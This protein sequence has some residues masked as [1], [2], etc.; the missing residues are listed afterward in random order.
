MGRITEKIKVYN[1]VDLINAETGLIKK[2]LIRSVEINALLDTG[3][4]FVCLPRTEI[5]KLGLRYHK[6]TKIR[7]ANGEA[8]RRI[9]EGAKVELKDR[10][11]EMPIMENDDATP[12]LI[13]YLLLEALDYVIDPQIQRVIPNPAHD[14]K[15]TADL[16]LDITE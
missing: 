12:S 5:E 1:L 16:Y 13:G 4:T 7:T 3:A 11:I 14:G 8:Q 15:W 10:A 9:F 2:N 6:T